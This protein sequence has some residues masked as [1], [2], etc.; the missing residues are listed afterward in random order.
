[1][2][3]ARRRTKQ[4]ECWFKRSTLNEKADYA[5]TWIERGKEKRNYQKQEGGLREANSGKR[6]ILTVEK[7]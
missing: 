2:E 5:K 7:A 4:K 6:D 1:L 3:V